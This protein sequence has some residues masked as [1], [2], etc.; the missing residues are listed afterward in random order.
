MSDDWGL[1]DK[2]GDAEP[3]CM[4]CEATLQW[5]DCEQCE[6]G[7]AGHD[8]GEDCCACLDPELNE[9][10]DICDGMGGWYACPVCEKG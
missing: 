7:M 6:D 8:C 4:E 1:L 3:I 5:F 10:C 9:A 2:D